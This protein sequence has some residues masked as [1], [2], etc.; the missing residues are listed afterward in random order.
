MR[1]VEYE[2]VTAAPVE[3]IVELYK[4]GDWWQESPEARECHIRHD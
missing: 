1:E 2:I 4:A 3:E